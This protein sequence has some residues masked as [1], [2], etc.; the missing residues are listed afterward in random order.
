MSQASFVRMGRIL[1]ST[2]P[3]TLRL[4]VR[5]RPV[6]ACGGEVGDSPGTKFSALEST[7]CRPG[8]IR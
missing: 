1:E 8:G 4:L 6:L 2:C 7:D 3:E 5:I